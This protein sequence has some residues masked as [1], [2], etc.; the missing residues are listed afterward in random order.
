MMVQVLESL[1]SGLIRL[2]WLWQ[3]LVIEGIWEVNQQMKCIK[4][5][6]IYFLLFSLFVPS[7]A[8]YPGTLIGQWTGNGA[9]GN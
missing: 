8:A 2:C 4:D 3:G 1:I 5:S 7:S 6:L 9:A